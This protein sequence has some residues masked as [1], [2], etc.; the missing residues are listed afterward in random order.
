M[1]SFWH[2]I[3]DGALAKCAREAVQAIADDL[4]T[5]S[6]QASRDVSLAGGCAGLAV[7]YAYLDLANGD[8]DYNETAVEFLT[9]AMDAVSSVVMSPSLYAGF[10]GVG[11][12]AEHLKGGPLDPDEDINQETDQALKGYLQQSPWK[13]DYDLINGLVGVG[14]YALERLPCE[15]AK[16]CIQRIVDRLDE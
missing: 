3:L 10:T 1:S 6:P 12:A 4:R 8:R 13:H 14:V 2:P 9:Q 11:W 15:A 5:V 7:L 16:D